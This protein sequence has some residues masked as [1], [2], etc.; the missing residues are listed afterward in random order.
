[1]IEPAFFTAK[2]AC[3]SSFTERKDVPLYH[4]DVRSWTVTG[5][6][7]EIPLSLAI[8][9]RGRQNEAAWMSSFREQR[10][11]ECEVLPIVSLLNFARP[12]GE[13]CS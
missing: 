13:T 12:R 6:M 9:S 11:L 1:M 2:P 4:P 8:I 3:S 5:R 7:G 10:K